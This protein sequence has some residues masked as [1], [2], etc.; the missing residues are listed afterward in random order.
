M[1]QPTADEIRVATDTIRREAAIWDECSATLAMAREATW[2]L[3]IDG[4]PPGSIFA[5]FIAAYNEAV[6]L[7][8]DRFQQ[9]D[10][11]TAAV[12]AALR[13]VADTYDAEEQANLHALHDLY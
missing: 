4:V 6:A 11:H 10:A 2:V 7:T 13:T 8:H 1:T 9:G 3:P 12:G 5:E